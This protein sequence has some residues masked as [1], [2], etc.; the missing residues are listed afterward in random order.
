[1]HFYITNN[2]IPDCAGEDGR[3][4]C[5]YPASGRA[6]PTYIL[7][8]RGHETTLPLFQNY[9]STR[10]GRRGWP[11]LTR[12]YCTSLNGAIFDLSGWDLVC[13]PWPIM[14]TETACH[15][16]GCGW[17][18]NFNYP[19][20]GKVTLSYIYII[21]GKVTSRSG[22][23]GFFWVYCRARSRRECLFFIR[24]K[25][26]DVMGALF[27]VP[28]I[29]LMLLLAAKSNTTHTICSVALSSRNEINHWA[30]GRKILCSSYFVA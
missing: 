7:L 6:V 27:Y 15:T 11:S 8:P 22:E 18:A 14:R 3:V 13:S 21:K 1:M 30:P 5:Y 19:T 28:F 29:S 9:F 12:L 25:R 24:G 17:A 2:V 20:G 23:A 26:G 16:S 10:R 4:L